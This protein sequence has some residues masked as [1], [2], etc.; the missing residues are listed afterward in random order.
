MISP[1]DKLAEWNRI[2]ELQTRARRAEEAA[3]DRRDNPTFSAEEPTWNKPPSSGADVRPAPPP[4]G[5]RVVAGYWVVGPPAD[6]CTLSQV[7]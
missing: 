2:A 6:A 4:P 7:G 1:Q 3:R 5:V